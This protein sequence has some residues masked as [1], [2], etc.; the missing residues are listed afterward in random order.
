MS[1]S[2]RSIVAA[3]I[4][5]LA[6]REKSFSPKFVFSTAEKL[7]DFAAVLVA[8]YAASAL[9]QVVKR[10]PA[11]ALTP[12]TFFLCAVAF[13][14]LIVFLLERRGGYELSVSLLGIRE[15]ER[16]LRVTLQAFLLVLVAAYLC[17]APVSRLVVSCAAITVPFFLTIEKW[18][19]RRLLCLLRSK[20]YASR[21]AVIFGIGPEATRVYS[22]LLRSP[23][24][25]VN[26]VAFVSDDPDDTASEIYGPSY[27][28]RHS[29]KVF[30]GPL[31]P[32]LFRQLGASVLVV[33]S[34]SLDRETLLLTMAKLARAGISTYFSPGDL[35]EPGYWMD[36]AELDGIMLAHFPQGANRLFYEFGKRILDIAAA[37]IGMLLLAI[38][39]PAIALGVK[40][41]SPGPVFFRQERIGKGGRRFTMFKF[42]TMY[43]DAP[44][45]SNSPGA[46]DDPRVTPLGRFLRHTSLDELPQ[47]INVL[48][49]QMSLVGPRP[50]MPFIVE[51]YSPMQRQRLGVKPGL[52][53]L[54]QISPARGFPIHENLEYDL[55]YL[56]NNPQFVWD[57][58]LQFS[59]IRRFELKRS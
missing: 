59:R 32:E 24:F 9:Y 18:E 55:Y 14:L 49:G 1:S 29:A 57:I 3:E 23:K 20:G 47:L 35:L 2:A 25:G 40:T 19:M 12:S 51:Q 7:L 17:V 38:V 6:A 33:A 46:G 30:P 8:V 16:I 53:G 22:A 15:T 43:R 39:G 21:T 42:R 37:A 28:R 36:Y 54:W 31:C 45:Y 48:L 4:P 11:A 10:Q 13:A 34:S 56:T 5:Q 27:G 26:P 58:A 52:T 44:V 50:E 41:T